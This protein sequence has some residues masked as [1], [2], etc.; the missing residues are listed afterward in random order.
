MNATLSVI[1]P[2]QHATD[3]LPTQVQDYLRVVP[4]HCTD[5]EIILVNDGGDPN[6]TA[7]LNELATRHDP[8]LVLHLA[9]PRGYRQALVYG[10]AYARGDYLLAGTSPS[11]IHPA[12][13]DRL[14]P[15]S[16][17]H[18]LVTAYRLEHVHHHQ[19]VP[20]R[21]LR[22]WINRILGLELRDPTCCLTLLHADLLH[23]LPLTTSDFLI[24]TELY[25][26]THRQ[27]ACIQV[28]VHA[29]QP[30]HPNPYT[31]ITPTTFAAVV[32]LWLDLH[33]L[34]PSAVQHRLAFLLG[35]AALLRVGQ[36]VW[37]R[38]RLLR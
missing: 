21:L 24:H 2:I 29:N 22:G 20:D 5:F 7:V 10:M 30:T 34:T 33:G 6:T 32:A 37:R 18:V 15:F 31:Q 23:D 12:E 27:Q 14:I 36:I 13:L 25:A 11:D 8:V 9:E 4:R 35:V 28:G 1:L 19:P 3:S 16:E 38:Q 26:R 17:H